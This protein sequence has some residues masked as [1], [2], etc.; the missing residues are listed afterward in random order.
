MQCRTS[1]SIHPPHHRAG[2]APVRPFCMTEHAQRSSWLHSH[3]R[4]QAFPAVNG[5]TVGG[6]YPSTRPPTGR[7][8]STDSGRL[9]AMRQRHSFACPV[10][11]RQ[12]C[13]GRGGRERSAH[14]GADPFEPPHLLRWRTPRVKP[15]GRVHNKGHCQVTSCCKRGLVNTRGGVRRVVDCQPPQ[16]DAVGEELAVIPIDL[17]RGDS[18]EG[19]KDPPVARR[20]GQCRQLLAYCH[21]FCMQ[22]VKPA[23]TV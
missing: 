23:Y 10:S 20:T 6:R 22:K 9:K 18:K 5:Y 3:H 19:R 16:L 7:Y 13:P 14:T 2:F 12:V 11:P 1:A 8:H 15:S 17:N 4:L 21:S